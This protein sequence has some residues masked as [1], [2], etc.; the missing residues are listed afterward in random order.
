[1]DETNTQL[2]DRL[3]T[4]LNAAG[5]SQAELS[6]RSQVSTANIAHILNG[7]NRSTSTENLTRLAAALGVAVSWLAG[8]SVELPS[9]KPSNSITLYFYLLSKDGQLEATPE[10]KQY[11]QEFFTK[12]G[13][14]PGNCKLFRV[15][16]DAMIPLLY[17]SDGVLVDCSDVEPWKHPQAHVYA[18][19]ASGNIIIH[20]LSCAFGQITIQSLNPSYPPASFSISDFTAQYSI[21]GR[22]IDRFGDN[23][24]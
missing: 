12:K 5:I 10:S 7:R 24:L 9:N 13:I 1:M 4:A 19:A 8:V 22:V 16:S 15:E 20:R 21:I 3:R 23:G 6:R 2:K 18:I 14:A 11:E 17:P